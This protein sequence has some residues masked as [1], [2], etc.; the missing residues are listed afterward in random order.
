MSDEKELVK[1]GVEGAIAGVTEG[2]GFRDLVQQFLGPFATELGTGL[3][4]VGT[5]LRIKLGVRMMQRAKDM[6]AR[7][8]IQ[9]SAVPPK[10]FLPLLE[11]ASLEEDG[12]LQ[13]CWAALLAN[14]AR[15]EVRIK[16]TPSFIE[17]LK[18]LAPQEVGF[19]Q[20]LTGYVLK[21][22]PYWTSEAEPKKKYRD[23]SR[24]SEDIPVSSERLVR[25]W[26]KQSSVLEIQR[27]Q[28]LAQTY[29]ADQAA[30]ELTCNV[31][32]FQNEM[33]VATQNLIR[34]GLI[35][36]FKPTESPFRVNTGGEPEH[37]EAKNDQF[38]LTSLGLAFV[39]ACR[40]PKSD[41]RWTI[42]GMF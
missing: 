33:R 22:F 16:L 40:K 12:R 26:F 25:L 7:A 6:L 36:R 21:H 2:L 4:Y 29:S 28:E 20:S 9:P 32:D 38:C 1:V 42:P 41:F 19:L 10:L 18:Q 3:G 35:A 24:R 13:E 11:N 5:V 39:T 15:P 30:F 34:L 8:V 23:R 17:I 37:H 27:V 31:F 14:A